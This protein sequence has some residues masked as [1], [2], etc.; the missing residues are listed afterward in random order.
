M[1]SNTISANVDAVITATGRKHNMEGKR[2]FQHYLQ[3]TKIIV[4]GIC[5]IPALSQAQESHST[6]KFCAEPWPPY[7]YKHNN[8]VLGSDVTLNKQVL[9]KLDVTAQVYIMPWKQCWQLVKQ[10]KMDGALMV[11]KKKAREPY[12]YYPETPTAHLKYTWVTNQNHQKQYF[13][14]CPNLSTLNLTIGLVKDNSYS[15]ELLSCLAKSYNA[16]HIQTYNT[17]EQALRMLIMNKV[18]LIPAIPEVV[19]HLD[20]DIKLEGIV[21]HPTPIFSKTYYTVFSKKSKFSNDKYQDIEGLTKDFAKTLSLA[22]K[23]NQS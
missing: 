18:Q 7:D 6:L 19:E 13:D 21:I 8:T 10:G 16:K 4:L 20:K 5:A 17:L 11:S 2:L 14:L 9:N 1:I 22:N 3:I 12:V 23:K 15:S